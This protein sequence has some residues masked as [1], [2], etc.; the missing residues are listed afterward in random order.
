MPLSWNEI[1]D[2]ALRFSREWA[3]EA[4]EDAEA[5]S[6]WDGFFDIFG[7]SRRRTATFEKRVKKI[8]G[9]DGYIDLLWKGVLLVEHKSRGK[10]LDRAH[11]QARD[12]FHGLTDAE[13]P[14]YLLVSDFARFRLY[15]LEDDEAHV[16]FALKDLHRHVRRFGFIA[17]YQAR[18]FKDEDPVNM[19]AAERMGRLH[20]ALKASGYDGHALEVLLVRLLFCLFAEDTGIFPRAAFHELISQRTREDGSDLGL[21]LAQLF[22]TL[23]TPPERRQKTLDAQLAELPYVNGKLFAE[24]LPL[25]AFD[26]KMRAL[27]LDAAALDWSRISPAIFGSMF[28][29]VMDAK[30]RRNLGA[31]YTSEK[32]ILKLI[33]PLFLDE[34]TAELERIGHQAAKL[35]SFHVKLSNLRFLDPACGCGNFLVIA[36]RELRLLELEVL[37]RQ[38]DVQGS[39]LTR[40]AEHVAVDVDQFFGIE[41]EEFPAQIAQVA[42]WLMD[43]QMNLRVAEQFGEYFA[44]LPLVKSPTIVHGNALRMDWHDV[45]G[46]GDVDYILGNPPFIG[47]QHQDDTQKA[48]MAAVFDGVK[49]AGV[50][51]FVTAWYLRAAKFARNTSIRCAFVSTSSITQG[52]QVGVLWAEMYRCTMHIHFAHR[53]FTWSNEARGKAAVHCVIIGFGADDPKPKRLFDYDH[54]KA[55]PHERVAANINGYLVDAADVTLPNRREAICAVPPI[56]FGSMPNDGGHL[57]LSDDEKRTLLDKEP[58]AAPWILPFVG[59]EEF[60]NGTPRWCLWLQDIAPSTLKSLPLVTGRV[61]AVKALR[62]SSSRATTRELAAYPT[63][64]GEIRQP[65]GS[66]ILVPRHSSE[67]RAYIPLGFVGPDVICGDSNMLVPDATLHHFGVM[68]STMHMA[69]VRSVCGRLESRYRYSAGI[70][71]NNFP[72]PELP[73]ATAANAVKQKIEAAAQGVLDARA[74]F[75]DAT[76]ADLYDPLTMP[77][78]LVKAHQALDR[79]VDAAYVA[80]EKAAGRKAPKLGSDAERVAFL[81]ERYQALTSLLPAAKP[82][83]ARG[84]RKTVS[85]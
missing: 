72:W 49:G 24:P 46:G 2:R 22:Q 45:C 20:D 47:K 78:A 53:T 61:M 5:K 28:Q 80:A 52:E 55:D 34:L 35:K 62:Q 39:V 65:G 33:G 42:L 27:L 38:F 82:K 81:F 74:Q 83:R 6:F 73:D 56:V 40:V 84:T 26:A 60:I 36:Y 75:P 10:D 68:T 11:A 50:L 79:A 63:L 85:A 23:D 14:K 31:H 15:D 69:W 13:L 12:Y 67:N 70:V 76:L 4:S 64:F 7:V 29:S 41:I 16:E 43:H 19:K 3:D 48:D 9:K 77:P 51:D 17:G 1:K 25:A 21:W 71:Y 44:R 58:A 37:K 59:A 32:N 54:P 18:S 57:L 8:D 66:Y 30:A